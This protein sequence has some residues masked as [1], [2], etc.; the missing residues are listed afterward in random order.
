[1]ELVHDGSES[2]EPLSHRN[3]SRGLG[4]RVVTEVRAGHA[5]RVSVLATPPLDQSNGV[6]ELLHVDLSKSGAI[7]LPHGAHGGRTQPTGAVYRTLGVGRSR[8]RGH[9]RYTIVRCVRPLG[10]VRPSALSSDGGGAHGW[11][12]PLPGPARGA[13]STGREGAME[14]LGRF[15]RFQNASTRRYKCEALSKA[16]PLETLVSRDSLLWAVLGSN[17]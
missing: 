13:V 4:G 1:M 10:V 2:L 17:Q 16:G 15:Q 11:R 6:H 14:A 8:R 3:L 12:S 7:L 9:R 5:E